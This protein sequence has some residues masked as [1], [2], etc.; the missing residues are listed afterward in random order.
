MTGTEV[1]ADRYELRGVL[2]CGGMAEVRDGW[3]A[4][5]D[6]PVAVKLLH[7][8]L[9]AQPDVRARFED[10]ARSAARLSHP[11]IVGVHDFGEQDGVPFLVMERLPG[12]TLADVLEHGP[13]PTH[14]ARAMLGDVLAALEAAHDAGVLHRDIKPGNILVSTAG[15]T[16]KVADF[17]IAKTGGSAHTL[18]GQ[19]V[20]T[21]AYMSP[22]RVSGA[23]ASIADD[24]YA[25][26]VMAYEAVTGRDAFPQDNP[27][28]LARAILD[29]PPPP[30]RALGLPDPDLAAVIDRAMTRDPAQ[31]FATAGQMRAALAGDRT[32]MFA[33]GPP[34]P[35]RPTTRVLDAP[36]PGPPTQ[37]TQGAGRARTA[38]VAAGVLVAFAV[39]IMALAMDPFSDAPVTK[40]ISTSTEVPAPPPA[41]ALP[42][43]PP[44]TSVAP[45]VS[46]APAAQQ[47]FPPPPAEQPK[48]KKAGGGNG[49]GNGK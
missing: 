38:L 28:A 4:R 2:G 25:V 36:L 10:E 39:A 42:P 27:L 1:L 37:A 8:S 9:R 11:N 32:A 7:P 47:P 29:D 13:M 43:P 17:G 34:P 12:R 45:P 6:R 41:S 20:G 40:P 23:P 16:L 35:G 49:K 26:G 31:R 44:P 5:L 18:T 48:P 46:V 21:I 22:E 14:Q 19:L 24:L 33:A 15:D 30:L 3:D